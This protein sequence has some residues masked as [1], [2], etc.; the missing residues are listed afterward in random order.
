MLIIKND[1]KINGETTTIYINSRRYGIIETVI[2]TEDLPKVKQASSWHV[3]YQ[4]KN[5][6]WYVKGTIVID[7]NRKYVYL[8]RHVMGIDNPQHL[9][10]HL[11]HNALN[12][13]KDNLRIVNH[14]ENAQNS[15]NLKPNT[16]G[17]RGVYPKRDRNKWGAQITINNKVIHLGY[18][19]TVKKAKRARKNAEKEHFH[20]KKSVDRLMNNV[21]GAQ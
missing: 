19:K 17:V 5:D 10:D 15:R 12:N 6:L 2:D 1:Y 4:K 3:N 20:Y 7:G 8:H 13:R 11:D 9:I 14:S 21:D 18:F 16:S